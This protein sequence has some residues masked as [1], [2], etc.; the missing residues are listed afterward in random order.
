MVSIKLKKEL[1]EE[2]KNTMKKLSMHEV[3]EEFLLK[4]LE[5]NEGVNVP[6]QVTVNKLNE[7]EYE[8]RD[9]SKKPWVSFDVVGVEE[10]ATLSSVGLENLASVMKVKISNYEGEN[11]QRFVGANISVNNAKLE[12]VKDKYKN[13]IGLCFRMELKDIEVVA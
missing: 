12:F 10:Y 4:F 3:N 6:N 2:V 5:E 11:V 9:G 7:G 13:I 8:A 1:K